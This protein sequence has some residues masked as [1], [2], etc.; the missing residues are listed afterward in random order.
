[1]EFAGRQM[2]MDAVWSDDFA[3]IVG[4]LKPTIEKA[5]VK[6]DDPDDLEG[7]KIIVFA[8]DDGDAPA[9]GFKFAG[10]PV[11]VNYAVILVGPEA[12][13]VRPRTRRS[14]SSAH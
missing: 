14:A 13:I 11:A 6:A 5:L 7:L 9:W 3:K 8:E 4:P 2:P 12:P 1:M 10:L